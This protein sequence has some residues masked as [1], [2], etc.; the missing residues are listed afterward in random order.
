M[1]RIPMVHSMKFAPEQSANNVANIAE[2]SSLF[3]L[4]YSSPKHFHAFSTYLA[5]RRQ[6]LCATNLSWH[7]SFVR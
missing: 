2:V 6:A 4:H 3:T 7:L 1:K 5:N